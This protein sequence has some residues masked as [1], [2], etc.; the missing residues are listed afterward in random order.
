MKVLI[1][2]TRE[3]ANE[4]VCELLLL[5]IRTKPE[6][7]LGLATGGTMDPVYA[8]LRECGTGL[9]Y[10]RLTTFNLLFAT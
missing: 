2:P 3:E 6:S 1:F 9:D 5:Q 4:R 10:S 7:T 8:Q